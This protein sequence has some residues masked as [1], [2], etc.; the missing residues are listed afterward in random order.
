[1]KDYLLKLPLELHTRIKVFTATKG[2]TMAQFI[3][4]AVTEKLNKES[5]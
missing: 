2:I 3:V 4:E 1:M 5:K